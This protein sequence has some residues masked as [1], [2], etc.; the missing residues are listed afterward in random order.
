MRIEFKQNAKITQQK[1][2]RVPVQLQEAVQKEIERLLEE[3]HIEKVNE[4]TDKQLIQP[5]VI[6]VKKYK[7]V[8]IALD[9]RALNNE[10][11]KDKYQMPNLEHLVDLVAEQLD[12]KEQEKALDT[13]LDLRYAYGQVPLE[14]E[15]AKHCNFQII[16]GKATGTYRFITGFYGLT[17]MPTE[18]QKAMDKE[19]ANLQNTYVFLDDILIVEKHFEAV[20][21]VL[22][23]LDNANV[24]LKWEK[25]K[26]AEEEIEWLGYKLSQTGI[27]PVNSKV[28]AI[29]EKLTP[30]SLKELWSYLGAVYQLN[31]FIPN[32]AQLFHELRPQ[33]KKDQPWKWEEK[34]DKAIQK[35]NE[36]VKQVTEVGHFK[37]SCPI[38]IICD[39]S[40]L[41]LG[42]VLQQKD[43]N[44]NN[45]RPIHFAS[46]F[47]TPL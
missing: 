36:K 35:I 24:R 22:K 10:V 44:E 13:S 40:K 6:T 29:T 39:A 21:Q 4:V 11:V 1:G 12:N 14:K 45:W 20:K 41:G 34:H 15:T 16:G 27:K 2:R 7:G 30:K 31:C 32:L 25:C 28:Q 46:R 37:R 19:L 17:I 9:V 38:R 33:L 8:K 5:V 26:F 43:G 18:F 23:R 3:G 47:S 42:A